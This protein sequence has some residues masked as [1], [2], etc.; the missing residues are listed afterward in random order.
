MTLTSKDLV[1]SPNGLTAWQIY[2]PLCIF[3]LSEPRRRVLL[4]RLCWKKSPESFINVPSLYHCML[5]TGLQSERERYLVVSYKPVF[6][7]VC[8]RI[9]KSKATAFLEMEKKNTVRCWSGKALTEPELTEYLSISDVNIK[10]WDHSYRPS[11]KTEE[12]NQAVITE[13]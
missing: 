10:I 1:K 4:K 12:N 2:F 13:K 11:E 8:T 3:E 5:G 9:P 7:Q 6:N